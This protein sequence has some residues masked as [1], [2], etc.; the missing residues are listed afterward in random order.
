MRILIFAKYLSNYRKESQSQILSDSS[1]VNILLIYIPVVRAIRVQ[2][3]LL[4]LVL[5]VLLAAQEDRSQPPQTGQFYQSIEQIPTNADGSTQVVIFAA[6]DSNNLVGLNAGVGKIY[7]STNG[8]RTWPEVFDYF[9]TNEPWPTTTLTLHAVAY[10]S[11]SRIIVLS[12][13]GRIINTT[14]GGTTWRVQYSGR[15]TPLRHISMLDSNNGVIGHVLDG[16]LLRTTDGGNTWFN[17][18]IPDSLRTNTAAMNSV[19]YRAPGKIIF[20]MG[21]KSDR[22]IFRTEDDGKTWTR[23]TFFQRIGAEDKLQRISQDTIFLPLSTFLNPDN[24]VDRRTY[25]QMLR[26][27]DGGYTWHYVMNGAYYHE[28]GV[29]YVSFNDP[30]NGIMV[31]TYSKLYFTSDG[32]ETWTRDST[33][34]IQQITLGGA[35]FAKPYWVAPNLVFTKVGYNFLRIRPRR[36]PTSVVEV[37]IPETYGLPYPNPANNFISVPT[38]WDA[39]RIE[40][41]SALGECVLSSAAIGGAEARIDVR[42]FAAGAYNIRIYRNNGIVETRTAVITR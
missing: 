15:P 24:S 26:S 2:I 7:S 28:W 38:P 20:L 6:A 41:Y 31:G 40:L 25:D 16:T 18:N 32:G 3:A 9:K 30:K 39:Q 14:D 10:P 35:G 22:W 13:S 23:D 27:T 29:D 33:S 21:Y 37:V 11:P 19:L 4:F 36:P 17:M 8:G 42:N 1:C 12:D 34:L 5:P